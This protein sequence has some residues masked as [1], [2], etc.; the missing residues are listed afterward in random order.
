MCVS[1]FSQYQILRTCEN[2]VV[3]WKFKSLFLKC[4]VILCVSKYTNLTVLD[5]WKL[6]KVHK[7]KSLFNVLKHFTHFKNLITNN[8]NCKTLVYSSSSK[9][10]HTYCYPFTFSPLMKIFIVPPQKESVASFLLGHQHWMVQAFCINNK[11]I[12]H[13]YG[14]LLRI[15]KRMWIVKC[16]TL[17]WKGGRNDTVSLK[18]Q[19]WTPILCP[20]SLDMFRFLMAIYIFISICTR[21]ITIIWLSH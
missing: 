7:F 8:V 16:G 2:R 20:H 14:P 6:T 18:V 17:A 3:R 15:D 4:N 9:H 13:E 19:M 11:F 21:F 10:T 1:D 5:N 12:M